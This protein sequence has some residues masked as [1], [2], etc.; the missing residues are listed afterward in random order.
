MHRSISG[1]T[2]QSLVP[3]PGTHTR[4]CVGKLGGPGKE[5]GGRERLKKAHSERYEEN[6][7]SKVFSINA[8]I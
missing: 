8:N 4:D 7:F 1:L 5:A 2:H 3:S 6:V